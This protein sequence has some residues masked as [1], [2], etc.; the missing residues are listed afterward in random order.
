MKYLINPYK[1]ILKFHGR[2]SMKQYWYFIIIN[3]IISLLLI[4]TKKIHG[5]DQIEVYF[6][7]VTIIPLIS[8][9]FRRIQ[10]TGKSGWLSLIPIVNLVIAGFVEGD[11]EENKYGK[12]ISH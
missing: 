3:F 6:R 4:L 2:A 11:K 5:I 10:D 1:N 12:P 9:G 8:L 7:Y